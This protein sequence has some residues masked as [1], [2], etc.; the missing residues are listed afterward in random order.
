MDFGLS[1]AQT[2]HLAIDHLCIAEERDFFMRSGVVM[3]LGLM[4]VLVGFSTPILAQ[5][6]ILSSP[7]RPNTAPPKPR[8]GKSNLAITTSP[9]GA[10]VFV[11]GKNMGASDQTGAFILEFIPNRSYQIEVRKPDF[12]PFAKSYRPQVNKTE[13]LPVR[14]VAKFAPLV[15]AGVPEGASLMLD[16]QPVKLEDLRVD[17]KQVTFPKLATGTHTVRIEHADW[18]PWEDKVEIKPDDPNGNVVT[19]PLVAAL[20]KV[21]IASVVGAT[22]YVDDADRGTITP[23]GS[24]VI[25][26]VRPGVRTIRVVKDDYFE[27]K[28]TETL[29]VGEKSLKIDLMPIPSSAEFSDRFNAGLG[30]WE[31]PAS[32]TVSKGLMV[33]GEGIGQ[34]AGTVYRDFDVDFDIQF[35]NDKGA[36]WVIRARNNNAYVFYLSG[37]GGKHPNEFRG[38]LVRNGQLDLEKPIEAPPILTD[39]KPNVYYHVHIEVRGNRIKHELI[40]SSGS[41]A[42]QSVPLGFLEDPQNSFKLG[43]FG[44]RTVQ[45]EEFQINAFFIKPVDSK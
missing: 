15:L 38:Y 30:K 39:I 27:T 36:A 7:S 28:L 45:G 6:R 44:F 21:T 5:K 32:W 43:N 23:D 26:N 8:V 12:E 19:P 3:V 2:V 37:P 9:I 4:V 20:V 11:D 14:L 41:D 16:N 22:V 10:E 31:A 40:P 17:G 1:S 34:P 25:P 13:V 33:K 35:L 42:G 18:M 29:A 24:L